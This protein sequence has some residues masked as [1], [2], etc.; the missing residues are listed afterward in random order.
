ME[1]IA[2]ISLIYYR[3]QKN[4]CKVKS[5][6]DDSFYNFNEQHQTIHKIQQDLL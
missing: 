6:F 5:Q 4:L 2:S 1:G 3:K